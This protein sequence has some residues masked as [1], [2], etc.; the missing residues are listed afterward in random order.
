MVLP[1]FLHK[2][3]TYIRQGETIPHTVIYNSELHIVESKLYGDMSLGEVEEIIT[4][5]AKTT[6][7][8]D[9]RLTF[10]DFRDTSRKSS[11]LQI[12]EL[13]DRTKNTFAS[14][15]INVFLYKRANVVAA[16]DLHDYV[17]L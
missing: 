15:G 10:I 14:F 4:K 12:Y 1:R 16:K 13:P 9:C 5:I 2:A 7:E 17:F 8:N 6:K 3:T 11:I